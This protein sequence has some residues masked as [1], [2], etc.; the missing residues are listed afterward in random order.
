MPEGRRT[1]DKKFVIAKLLAYCRANDWSGYDPYDALNSRIFTAL[2]FLDKKIPRL[3]L[4]QVLKRSPV[5][6]RRLLLVPPTQNPKALA[7]FLSALLRLREQRG[8]A[9]LDADLRRLIER[10]RALRSAGESY[11]CWG[12]SFPW[13]TRRL[14]VPAGA[15]N[16]VCT[17]FVAN[18]LLD[19]W[20]ALGDARC[21]E[22]AAS[23]AEYVAQELYWEDGDAAGFGY[24]TPSSRGRVHNAN[25]L[26][27]ALL[28]RVQ[29]HSNGEGL[30]APALK[31]ARY[32]A[33]AQQ[34]DGS[35]YYGE[36]SSQR[37]I[38]NFHTGYNLGALK[39]IAKYAATDE[40]EP[41]LISG[42]AFYREHFFRDNGAV[43]YFHD[44]VYPI[45]IHCVAQSIITLM[46]F[47]DRDPANAGLARSAF[48]WA[49]EHLWDDRGYFYYRILRS[50]TIRTSYM[51]W[52]QAWMLLALT[53]L[54][55]ETNERE[56]SGI[57]QLADATI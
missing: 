46:D 14:V 43:K 30:L 8:G 35:W 1:V 10:L 12:Y 55:N 18:A 4:T 39:A 51:R 6:F 19:A 57:S 36:S 27:A 28:C 7:L 20:E 42:L 17:C 53:S 2:P 31:A 24:P 50:C 21:L 11:S 45:D 22:M 25:L 33:R 3:V 54:L 37:W 40:F 9:D 5:N 41:N 56:G 29:Y 48:A 47:A 34:P 15:P 49:M 32:A 38:D 13:Q 16:L 23:A 26:A 44:R 52:S